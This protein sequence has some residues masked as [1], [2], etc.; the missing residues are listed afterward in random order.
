[1][2]QK[3]A[4][5]APVLPSV[6][7]VILVHLQQSHTFVLEQNGTER[8]GTERNGT[9]RN[10]TEQNRTEQNRTEQNRTEQPVVAERWQEVCR[11]VADR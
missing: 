3:V 9:E 7:A 8:N 2:A 5:S 6:V 4:F 10:G 1:M 11:A